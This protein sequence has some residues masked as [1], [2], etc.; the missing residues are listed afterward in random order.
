SSLEIVDRYRHR[1]GNMPSRVLP[2]RPRVEHNDAFRSRSFQQLVHLHGLG[3]GTLTEMLPE[4]T[5]QICELTLGDRSNRPAQFEDGGVRQAIRDE[6][7]F[8]A[9]LDQG[10]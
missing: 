8:F 10:S 6:Q 1:A 7:A 4:Q 9:T 3:V 2:S 5:F